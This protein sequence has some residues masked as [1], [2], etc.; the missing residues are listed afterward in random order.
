MTKEEAAKALKVSKR[1]V[2]RYR[3]ELGILEETRKEILPSHLELMSNWQKEKENRNKSRVEILKEEAL[4]IDS[5]DSLK[6]EETDS[7]T[8]KNLKTDYNNNRKIIDYFQHISLYA[9]NN[10]KMPPKEILQVCESYQKL[11]I[12]ILNSLEK[13]AGKKEGIESLILKRLNSYQ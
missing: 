9:A 6:I 4:K 3:K 12:H 2:D 11:N 13:Q 7:E 1:T 8:V 10:N 5:E